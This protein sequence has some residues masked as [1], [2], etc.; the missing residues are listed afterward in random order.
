[1]R[2]KGKLSEE[3]KEEIREKRK[4][5]LYTL[6]R[7][8]EEYGVS[9]SAINGIFNYQPKKRRRASKIEISDLREDYEKN[10]YTIQELMAEYRFNEKSIMK[11][12]NREI[13]NY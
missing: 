2:C 11:I 3:Q 5:P 8:A 9:I 1:M 7:L 6:R 13:Y 10:G 4:S 12:L